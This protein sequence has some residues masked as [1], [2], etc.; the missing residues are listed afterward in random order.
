MANEWC[1]EERYSM[2]GMYTR[3]HRSKSSEVPLSA[4]ELVL[5]RLNLRL[6]AD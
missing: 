2:R 4:E 3:R 5:L 1:M 6:Y